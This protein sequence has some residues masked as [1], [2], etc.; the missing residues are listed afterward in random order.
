M[1]PSDTRHQGTFR[2]EAGRARGGADRRP[3]HL[4]AALERAVARWPER[5]AVGGEAGALSYAELGAHVERLASRLRAAGLGV[6]AAVA[7]L[8]REVTWF[9]VGLHAALRAGGA[10][11]PLNPLLRPAEAAAL[12]EDA[13]ADWALADADLAH[14]LGPALAER[15]VL[16]FTAADADR[17]AGPPPLGAGDLAIVQYTSGTLGE[18]RGAELTHGAFL[19]AR[20]ILDGLEIGPGD[21]VCCGTPFFAPPSVFFQ[22]VLPLVGATFVGWP[23]FVAERTFDLL[24]RFGATH[25][26]AVPTMLEYLLALPA[27]ARRA[28]PALRVVCSLGAAASDDLLARAA[29][30]FAARTINLYGASEVM[31]VAFDRP[32]EPR[33]PGAVGRPAPGARVR[34]AA[35]SPGPEG[36]RVG[37][38]LVQAPTL[39]RGYRGRPT[40]TAA[41]LRGG[42]LRTGD[43][44]YLD[45]DGYL[46]LVDR[47]DS[48][49]NRGGYKVAPAEVERVLGAHPGVREVAVVGV[50]DPVKGALIKALVVPRQPAPDP[51]ALLAFCRG[52]LAAYKVPD[53][54]ELCAELPR[55]ATGKIG[56]RSLVEVAR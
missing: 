14:E 56:R 6:G 46:Y 10:A 55:T 30:L 17:A 51:E 22:T 53:L 21:V 44:G 7:V 25:F 15:R 2:G 33:R 1:G 26:F 35:A 29:E 3:A 42:W 40:E 34:I 36:S 23:R 37:E 20:A 11:V 31:V 24:E 49:I 18:P 8:S 48:M 5:L 52:R 50:P 27:T 16:P 47:I 54:V 19:A 45:G 41:K 39:M 38:V 4:V 9:D 28:L 32:G 13:R 12:L 43:L